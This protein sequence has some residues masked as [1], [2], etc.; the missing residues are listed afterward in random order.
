MAEK[1]PAGPEPIPD[2]LVVLTFDDGCS[3]DSGFVVPT[4][5]RYGFGA[6]FFINGIDA[7]PAVLKPHRLSWEQARQISEAGFEI[8][9]HLNHHVSVEG[10]APGQLAKQLEQVERGCMDHGIARPV[11]FCYPGFHFDAAA[12]KVLAARGYLFARR[13]PFPEYEYDTQGQRGPA[14]DPAVDHPLLIPTTGFAGPHYRLEDLA[15]AIE[16]A[17]GGRI[18]VLC[19][20]GVPDLDHAWV[21]TAPEVFVRY[22]DCLRDAGCTV[23]A[24]RDLARYVDPT[25]G[26]A[27]PVAAIARKPRCR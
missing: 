24:M 22:M 19:F 9:N 8:G 23:I 1:Q 25:A 12:V 2:R 21:S 3:S 20:H 16:R 4:L 17:R 5:A 7:L 11:S 6:T 26:P 15:W 27:D 10:M 13:G 14:Y 18:A